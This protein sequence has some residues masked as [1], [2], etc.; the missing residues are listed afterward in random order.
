MIRRGI[1]LLLLLLTIAGT[2]SAQEVLV[3][4]GRVMDG[5]NGVPY[6]TLQLGNSMIG[7]CC[8]D[9]GDYELKVPAEHLGDSILVRSVGYTPAR[10]SVSDLQRRNRIKLKAQAV[11]LREVNVST[12]RSA[13]HLMMDVILSLDYNYHQDIA[14]STFFYRDWR[15][16]DN[17]I[18][19]FDEAVMEVERA[20]YSQ[21][22][23]KSSYLFNPLIREMET[24]Y[25]TLLR[26]RLLVNDRRLLKEKVGKALGVDEMMEYADDKLFYDPAAAPNASFSLSKSWLIRQSFKPLMEFT[27]GG[28][29]YYLVRSTGSSSIS[30]ET[31]YEYVVRKRGLALVRITSWIDKP[32]KKKAPEEAWVKPYFTKLIIEADS[33][34]WIYD[35]RDGKLTLARYYSTSTT[36]LISKGRGHD[37]EEQCWRQSVDWTLTHFSSVPTVTEGEAVDSH[38]RTL[39]S[40]FGQSDFTPA[41]WGNYNTI[42]IDS[43]P[44]HLLEMKVLK[45]KKQ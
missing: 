34:T 11:E 45:Y 41:F 3:L 44:L 8:N 23:E 35:E 40:A 36:R 4:K 5:H 31:N 29:G 26:H 33:T 19:L 24:N 42:P 14:Y 22:A 17:E 32:V 28:E 30:R 43:L 21:Y 10:F 13:L 16:V 39:D 2:A 1:G 37:N 9:Q 15:A 18:Y 20:P 38:P 27:D 7:V 12:Y 6:A 25:K